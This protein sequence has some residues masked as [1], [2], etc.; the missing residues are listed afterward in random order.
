MCRT[1]GFVGYIR[2]QVK[3]H[4]IVETHPDNE[5]PD[6]RLDRPFEGLKNHCDSIDFDSLD[7]KDHSHTPYVVILY[8]YLRKW[9][10]NHEDIPKSRVEKEEFKK[11]IKNGIRKDENDDPLDEE[12][13]Q[14]ALKAVNTCICKTTV[15]SSTKEVLNDNSCVNLNA[16][17][18]T[19]LYYLIK[20]SQYF[21]SFLICY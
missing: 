16:K 14:E 5:I 20:N 6:L 4:T 1:I 3:E 2:V 17:V 15:S 10:E 8:K 19:Y 11:M 7:L 9:L 12:N 21:L 18:N 13:F